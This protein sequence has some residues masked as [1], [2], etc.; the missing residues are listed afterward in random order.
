MGALCPACCCSLP[1]PP[2]SALTCYYTTLSALQ[3]C[4]ETAGCNAFTFCSQTGGC[5]AGC[6]FTPGNT[7]DKTQLG[8]FGSCAGDRYPH[9]MCSFKS[10]QDASRPDRWEAG[11]DW[12]S[13]VVV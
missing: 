4:K 3:A 7:G 9:L 5:G 13:G 10:V 6:V 11:G 8:R 2:L 1:A 12:V